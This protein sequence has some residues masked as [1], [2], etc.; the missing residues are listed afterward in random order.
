MIRTLL[1]LAIC[2]S[3]S[4]VCNAQTR[5]PAKKTTPPIIQTLESPSA[6]GN[7]KFFYNKEDEGFLN[8][9]DKKNYVIINAQG[10]SANDIKSSIISTLS[11]MY[12]NPSKVI[13]ILGDNIINVNAYASDAFQKPFA[14]SVMYYSFTYNIKIEIKEGKI[15]VDSPS[16]SKITEKEVFMGQ[17]MATKYLTEK[18]MYTELSLAKEIQQTKIE[19]LINSHI[20]QIVSGL[21]KSDW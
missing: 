13:S 10:K 12:A 18:K 21:S 11:S 14:S 19:A 7:F 8:A 2:I 9:T 1:F 20:T 17:A 15:K 5:K 6:D 4:L 16:F 3:L